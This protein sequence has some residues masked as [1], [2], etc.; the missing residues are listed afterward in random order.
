MSIYEKRFLDGVG[1]FAWW[2]DG[3]QHVGTTGRLL[4]EV[5]ADP[6]ACYGF[7]PPPDETPGIDGRRGY[8]ARQLAENLLRSAINIAKET[9]PKWYA[10]ADAKVAAIAALGDKWEAEWDRILKQHPAQPGEE[11]RRA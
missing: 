10:S 7:D 4:A 1:A 3:K 2:K 11:V 9:D 8:A 6:S 5:K